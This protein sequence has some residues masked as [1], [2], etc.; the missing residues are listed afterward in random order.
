MARGWTRASSS[1]ISKSVRRKGPPAVFSFLSLSFHFDNEP[2]AQ[3]FSGQA[4][5]STSVR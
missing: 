3:P 1:T 5:R 2:L 4:K